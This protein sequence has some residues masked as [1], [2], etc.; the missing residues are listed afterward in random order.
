MYSRKLFITLYVIAIMAI[1]TYSYTSFYSNYLELFLVLI[2]V[3]RSNKIN[4]KIFVPFVLSTV[5]LVG[6]GIYA[7]LVKKHHILDFLL[8]Y[9]FFIYAV[10]FS[11]LVGKKFLNQS[12]F[13]DFYRFLIAA[14]F[15]KYT[16]AM[17]VFHNPRPILFHENNYELMFLSLLFYLYYILKKKVSFEHQLLLSVLFLMSGSKSGLLILLFVLCVVNFKLLIKRIYIILPAFIALLLAVLAVFSN[18]MGGTLNF[19]NTDRFRFL[20]VFA[21]ETKSWGLSEI[22]FG[23]SRIT[24]LSAKGCG[25]LAYYKDLFSYSGD[26]SCYSVI[27][28]SYI[29]RAVFDHGIIG[30]LLICAFVYYAVVL[31]GFKRKQALVVLGIA[32]VNGL[33]VSSFNSV[34]F[35]LGVSFFLI[36]NRDGREMAF[37][38]YREGLMRGINRFISRGGNRQMDV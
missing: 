24:P 14:F 11:F 8:I 23:S 34:Y 25:A 6:S 22:L 17:L 30:L 2:V 10:F 1:F 5:Y 38:T 18:R 4:R 29:L 26:G 20:M 3:L 7:V 13:V 33:S 37:S 35:A 15:V 9:K 19:E 28:H 21:E 27:F 32:L 31:S 36:L 16:L 12:W